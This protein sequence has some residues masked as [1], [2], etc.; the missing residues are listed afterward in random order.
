MYFSDWII[1]IMRFATHQSSQKL[2]DT[3]KLN[4]EFIFLLFKLLFS[5]WSGLNWIVVK[6]FGPPT[7]SKMKLKR[8]RQKGQ[9]KKKKL[10]REVR[11][12]RPGFLVVVVIVIGSILCF[13]DWT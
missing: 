2:Q 12:S 13:N 4:Y 5:N 6:L 9:N 7:F 3:H 1:Q 10:S 8:W 11:R